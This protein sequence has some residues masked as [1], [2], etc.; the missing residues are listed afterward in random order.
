MSKWSS[1]GHPLTAWR[2]FPRNTSSSTSR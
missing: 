1:L 2:A